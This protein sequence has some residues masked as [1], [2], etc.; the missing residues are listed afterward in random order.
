MNNEKEY[1]MDACR[2]PDLRLYSDMVER[3]LE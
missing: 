3:L 1:I 2:Y